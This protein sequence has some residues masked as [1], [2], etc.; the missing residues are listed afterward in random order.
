[1]PYLC[2]LRTFLKPGIMMLSMYTVEQALGRHEVFP[3]LCRLL[4]PATLQLPQLY[5]ATDICV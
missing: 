5:N 2:I 3:A 4:P 1:M